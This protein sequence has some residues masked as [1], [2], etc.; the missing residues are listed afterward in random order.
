MSRACRCLGKLAETVGSRLAVYF[1]DGK[2]VC[3]MFSAGLTPAVLEAVWDC[4]YYCEPAC[5]PLQSRLLDTVASILQEATSCKTLTSPEQQVHRPRTLSVMSAGS[6]ALEAQASS[7]VLAMKALVSFGPYDPRVKPFLCD[8]VLRCLDHQ[9]P[10]VRKM[11]AT[12]ITK[13]LLPVDL[14]DDGSRERKSSFSDET[15]T[16][17]VSSDSAD[18]QPS[19]GRQIV[20]CKPH[21]IEAISRVV[22]RLLVLAVADTDPDIRFSVFDG[23]D[24]RFDPFLSDRVC[25]AAITQALND[26]SLIVRK[27]AVKLLGRLCH[28]NP[29]YVLPA[30]R[31]LL[32]QLLTELEY[33]H[34]DRGGEEAAELLC[35]LLSKAGSHMSPYVFAVVEA[36]V[37]KL[38]RPEPI[39]PRY[40]SLLL[41]ALGQLSDISGQAILSS[42]LIDD[43]LQLLVDN[44]QDTRSGGE[45]DQA[46]QWDK[47]REVTYRTLSRVVENTGLV[48][49]PYEKH[50]PLLPYIIEFLRADAQHS[51]HTAVRRQAI[52]AIGTL[53][54][55]DPTRFDALKQI[56]SIPVMDSS[57]SGQPYQL[58]HDSRPVPTGA[59]AT[60]ST[61]L[62]VSHSHHAGAAAVTP[63]E[64]PPFEGKASTA[65]AAAPYACCGFTAS[66]AAGM[67]LQQQ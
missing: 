2:L 24:R 60:Q 42:G 4:C 40:T 52:R 49:V 33:N 44:V 27:A 55:L 35:D 67:D 7:A 62:A 31:K 16:T 8:T 64:H 56:A 65:A 54:A 47:K 57:G 29:A 3:L 6:A 23:I 13:L 53:G 12:T 30:L 18:L 46:A 63:A 19:R 38:C 15:P 34:A 20:L 51:A 10:L 37:S 17:E 48:V 32:I 45:G 59:T 41:E 25:I 9:H 36:V 21:H 26:E 58:F 39:S 1:E 66:I 14:P 50:P 11:A 61:V 5:G 22:Q 28:H 43:I